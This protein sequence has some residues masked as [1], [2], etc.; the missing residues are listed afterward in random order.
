MPN[1][2]GYSQAQAESA[3]AGAGLK[4]T[5]AD[6]QYSDSVAAGNV[7]SQTKSGETVAAGTTITLTLSKGKQEISTNVSKTVKL[8]MEGVSI[9]GGSY[10]LVGSD[11]KTYA[12]GD[13]TSSSVTV[14]GTMNCKTGTVTVTWQYTE[15]VKDENGN[16]TGEKPGEKT[17]SVQVP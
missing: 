4:Y 5:Y 13:V 7:I 8:D 16:V 10:S 15:P 6:S 14:S 9:T 17:I 1:V 12:S 2:V 11:G 3:L